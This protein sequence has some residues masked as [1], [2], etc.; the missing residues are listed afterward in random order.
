[1]INGNLKNINPASGQTLAEIVVVVGIIMLLITGLLVGANASLRAANFSRSKSKA[2][3]YAQDAVESARNLRDSSWDTF[4][5]YGD[6]T[7]KLWCLSG[8]GSW[9]TAGG[10]GCG[11]NINPN[12]SRSVKFTWADPNMKVDVTVYWTD[13][14]NNYNTT[15][16]TYFTDWR[17]PNL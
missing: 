12:Y 5:S 3:G 15:L 7:G 10:G 16:S 6:T 4:F 13:G 17:T 2:I 14:S 11:I 8:A 9:T 1:M